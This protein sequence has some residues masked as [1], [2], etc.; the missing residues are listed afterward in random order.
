MARKRKVS[1]FQNGKTALRPTEP[2][3]QWG[4]RVHFLGGVKRPERETGHSPAL[5]AHSL[6]HM[7]KWRAKGNKKLLPSCIYFGA[8]SM[9]NTVAPGT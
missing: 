6:P 4:R 3:T 9:F 5:N 1:I 7:T 2:C 8:L